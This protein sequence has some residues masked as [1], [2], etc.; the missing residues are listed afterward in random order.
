MSLKYTLLGFLSFAP[1]TGYDLKKYIDSS[2]E[3][4]WHAEL[5]QIY[6]TLKQLEETGLVESEVEPQEGKPDRKIYSLT[7]AGRAALSEWLNEPLSEIPPIKE[8]VLLQLFF[9]GALGKT[10]VLE[11][12]QRQL[13]LHRAKLKHYQTETKAVIQEVISLTGLKRD[14]VMWELTRQFGEDYEKHY[15]RWLER[16]IQTVD[17]NL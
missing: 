9:S 6:P 11:Q 17:E 13:A 2:T 1:M 7:K 4:F 10:M 8:P 16:A 15:I 14:G 5:A 3:F 12:L